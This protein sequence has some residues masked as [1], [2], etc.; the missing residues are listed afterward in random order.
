[1]PSMSMTRNFINQPRSTQRAV[2]PVKSGTRSLSDLRD[3]GGYL[4]HDPLKL[5]EGLF[6]LYLQDRAA[7]IQYPI[8]TLGDAI[9]FH[10]A[11]PEAL[12]EQPLCPVSIVGL[13]D[14]LFRCG[15]AQTLNVPAV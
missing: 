3:L 13:A 6:E 10:A 5:C 4:S 9:K 2:R 11:E 1:M 7:R 15:A 12:P 14:R 8:K